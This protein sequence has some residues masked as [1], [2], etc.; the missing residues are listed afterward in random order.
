ME[1]PESLEIS[2][3][4]RTQNVLKLLKAIYSLKQSPKQWNKK[5]NKEIKKL[6]FQADI[7]D[8]CLFWLRKGDFQCFLILYVDDIIIASTNQQRLEEIILKLQSVF[9]PWRT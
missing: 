6:S 9:Q 7:N 3:E 5:F 2:P 4:E 1:I 8:P